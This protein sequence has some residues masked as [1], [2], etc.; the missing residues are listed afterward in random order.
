M[1]S[2]SGTSSRLRLEEERSRL[3]NKVFCQFDMTFY[4]LYLFSRFIMVLM[5]ETFGAAQSPHAARFD[6]L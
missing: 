3:Q 1:I 2:V 4:I 5:S 6:G